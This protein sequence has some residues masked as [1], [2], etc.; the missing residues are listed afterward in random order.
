VVQTVAA[1][2]YSAAGIGGGLLA[3][4]VAFA[5]SFSFIMLGAARFERLLA[6][7]RVSSFLT[8][9]A[10]AAAGAIIGSAIPLTLALSENWQYPILAAAAVALLLLRRGVVLTLL[11]AGAI[12]LAAGLLGAPLPH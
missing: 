9:A 10:P 11:C 8:G 5:P 4:A 1:V 7:D 12:G 6:D 3:A 2:G